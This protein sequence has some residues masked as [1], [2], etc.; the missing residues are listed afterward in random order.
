MADSKGGL[1]DAVVRGLKAKPGQRFVR[2]D[3]GRG[4]E[5]GLEVRVTDK[6]VK[7]WSVR[8][9]RPSDGYRVRIKLGTFP[10][11]G[12]EAARVE[13]RAIRVALDKQQDPSIEREKRKGA[14][15]FRALA[16]EYLA[17]YAKNKRS[18]EETRRILER[19]WYPKI[20]AMKANEV[21]RLTITKVLED[22]AIKR[23]APV[24]A[25]RALAAV[26]GVYNWAVTTGRLEHT[27]IVKMKRL[28][29]EEA[30]TRFL[31]IDELRQLWASLPGLP[32]TDNI[33]DIV[34]LCLI[35]G[36]RVGEVAG[37]RKSEVNRDGSIWILPKDRTK[38]GV[39]HSVPL[40]DAAMA[41]IEPR[42]KG[43]GQ[44]LFPNRLSESEPLWASAPNKALQRNIARIGI[45]TFTVHDLRRTVNT[46]MARLG[47]NAETRSRVLNHVSAKRASITEAVYNSHS[48]DLEKRAALEAWA[49]ELI[50]I[51]SA[52]PSQSG[53]VVEMKP[54]G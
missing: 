49:R 2:M 8:Y 10:A 44:C 35:T 19:E 24:A 23:E 1:T 48:Y 36:Q 34:R 28:G 51:V 29:E 30:R 3:A 42:L 26:R 54:H 53:N 20:G 9:Y 12:L 52:V 14:D 46:H 47:V 32:I 38:N 37:L 31:N 41:I 4:A 7:T 15:T 25:N 50:A 40:S 27:P 45:P 39:A 21:Q 6:G 13:C 33:R 5:R 17:T 18:R 43:R 16:E 22:I 11:M